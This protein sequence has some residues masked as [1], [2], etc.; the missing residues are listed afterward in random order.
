M[1]AAALASAG[2]AR[3]VVT[4]SRRESVPGVWRLLGVPVDGWQ[5]AGNC[6]EPGLD[7]DLMYPLEGDGPAVAEAKA[8]CVDCPILAACLT[9]GMSE[10]AGVWGG[11]TAQERRAV[12]LAPELRTRRAAVKTAGG[13]GVAA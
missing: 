4:G 13:P 11:M 2:S 3:R 1:S 5:G 9:A 8:T 6:A 12:R 7:P 10:S